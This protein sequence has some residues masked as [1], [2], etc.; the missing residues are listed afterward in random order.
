M[1]RQKQIVTVELPKVQRAALVAYA[2][3]QGLVFK[4]GKP[5]VSA[6]LRRV[7]A[8]GLAMADPGD[9]QHDRATASA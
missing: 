5:N 7:I 1:D 3:R 6:A 8:V 9:G 2:R 4:S